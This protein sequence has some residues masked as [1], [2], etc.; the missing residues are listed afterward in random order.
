MASNSSRLSFPECVKS[1]SSSNACACAS[2]IIG[3]PSSASINVSALATSVASMSP[4]LSMSIC[5]DG[6]ELSLEATWTRRHARM[7]CTGHVHAVTARVVS[8]RKYTINL[9]LVPSH[10]Q[11]R[12]TNSIA[13]SWH[14]HEGRLDESSHQIFVQGNSGS[15]KFGQ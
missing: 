14:L 13:L 8:T 12:L 10:L 4:V 11:I 7:Q 9:G 1:N 5:K 6:R 2:V 3:A 15:A